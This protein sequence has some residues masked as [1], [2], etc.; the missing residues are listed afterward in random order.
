[1]LYRE[2]RQAAACIESAVAE[3]SPAGTG[4]ETGAARAATVRRR[5]VINV[6]LIAQ[7]EFAQHEITARAGNDN[8]AVAPA[9]A[10]ARLLCPIF[11]VDRRGVGKSASVAPLFE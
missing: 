1:M 5:A 8:L 7:H 9:P 6:C 3:Q 11:L 10:D 4:I 2:I